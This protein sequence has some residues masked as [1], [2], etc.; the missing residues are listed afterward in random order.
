MVRRSW[1]PKL[2]VAQSLTGN[3]PFA[4][5]AGS[6][7]DYFGIDLD[8]GSSACLA[9]AE[10]GGTFYCIASQDHPET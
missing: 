2:F 1:S 10:A 3:H 6:G 4:L 7:P 9:E 5:N 8:P